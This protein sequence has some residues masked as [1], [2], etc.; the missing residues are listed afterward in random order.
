MTQVMEGELKNFDGYEALSRSLLALFLRI[1]L[2]EN[3]TLVEMNLKRCIVW[4][5]SWE[6]KLAS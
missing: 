5:N 3:E 2:K 1:P 6:P 4:I